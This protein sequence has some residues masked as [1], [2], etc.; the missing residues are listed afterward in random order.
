M[1]KLFAALF[2][3]LIAAAPAAAQDYKPVDVHFGFDL[4]FPSPNLKN[5][6]DAGWNG[7]FGVT[8]NINEKIG[9][10]GE[11][12]YARMGGPDKTIS[13]VENPGAAAIT[14]GILES[15]HQMHVGS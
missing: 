8:Y 15:N 7:T 9:V 3:L 13:L 4:R 6:F 5:T 12:I 1:R 2:G 10:M 14:N 11:Y